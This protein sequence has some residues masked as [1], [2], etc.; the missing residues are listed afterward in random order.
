MCIM[1]PSRKNHV[2]TF[3]LGKKLVEPQENINFQL[4]W[5]RLNSLEMFRNS[6]N[7]GNGNSFNLLDEDIEEI[8]NIHAFKFRICKSCLCLSQC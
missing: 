3:C 8:G 7:H 4:W 1:I 2:F 5:K 6:K